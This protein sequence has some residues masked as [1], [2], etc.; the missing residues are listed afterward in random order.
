MINQIF[1]GEKNF[2][3][4]EQISCGVTK[5]ELRNEEIKENRTLSQAPAW[6]SRI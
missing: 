4:D 2:R 5:P 1:K 6:E 3:F